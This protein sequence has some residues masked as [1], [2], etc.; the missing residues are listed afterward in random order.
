MGQWISIDSP[1]CPFVQ[2][3]C[4]QYPLQFERIIHV[5]NSG[6][7]VSQSSKLHCSPH[8]TLTQ[9][10]V[11]PLQLCL[12]FGLSTCI[13]LRKVAFLSKLFCQ[14]KDCLCSRIFMTLAIENVY[15]TPIVQQCRMLESQLQTDI[16]AFCLHN[17]ENATSVVQSSTKDILRKDYDKFY[18][19]H[20]LTTLQPS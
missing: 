19:N 4:Q 7:E 13:F 8:N 12:Y 15:N 20:S 6:P 2:W 16:V 3:D 14:N 10:S 18:L 17:P 1:A 11:Y 9:P 5:L